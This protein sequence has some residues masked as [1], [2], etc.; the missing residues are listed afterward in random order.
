MTGGIPRL[1]I[2]KVVVRAGTGEVAEAFTLCCS[3]RR[4][5]QSIRGWGYRR[6]DRQVLG[7]GKMAGRELRLLADVQQGGA[8]LERHLQPGGIH[9]GDPFRIACRAALARPHRGCSGRRAVPPWPS[10]SPADTLQAVGW[11]A[12]RVFD[13][14]VLG[15]GIQRT[16]DPVLLARTGI[17]GLACSRRA[18][19]GSALR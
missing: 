2:D 10:S 6:S 13:P 9:L 4:V 18:A 5:R 17:Y 12:A 8:L 11:C 7:G 16:D 14:P 19:A 1:L 3:P 15:E